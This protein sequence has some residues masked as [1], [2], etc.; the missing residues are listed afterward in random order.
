MTAELPAPAT[1]KHINSPERTQSPTSSQNK[2]KGNIDI[3]VGESSTS[4]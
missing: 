4:S 3:V 1:F 2:R